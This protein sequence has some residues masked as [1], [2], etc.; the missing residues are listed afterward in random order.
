MD[1]MEQK[2]AILASVGTSH[3][4]SPWLRCQ[5]LD[6]ATRKKSRQGSSFLQCLGG[7]RVTPAK[8]LAIAQPPG[9]PKST[10]PSSMDI[11]AM[12]VQNGFIASSVGQVSGQPLSTN[13]RTRDRTGSFLVYFRI[14]APETELCDKPTTKQTV[15]V[16]ISVL[17]G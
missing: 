10:H 15:S 6:G 16:R 17:V 14:W 2:E 8:D 11:S 3:K 12:R 5:H 7:Q 9:T 1:S 4:N 13:R